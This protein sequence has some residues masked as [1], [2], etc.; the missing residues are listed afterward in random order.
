MC[1]ICGVTYFDRE[2][3]VT[4]REVKRMCD[5]IYHRGP[6]DSGVLIDGSTGLGMRRLSIIDL[7][8]GHQPISNEDGSIWIVF[9]GE[10]YNHLELRQELKK[11]GHQF[12]TQT[13]TEAIVHAYE[14]FGVDC[15]TKLN[16]MF[17][18]AIWDQKKNT[19]FLARDR[20]GIK[21]L[22]YYFNHQMLAFGSELKSILQLKEVPRE[23]DPQALDIYLTFEYIPSPYSIF[24]NIR[25][26]PPGHHLTL[27]NGQISIKKYWEL[28]YEER[29]FNEREFEE[30][31]VALL[32]DAVKIRLMSDV[33]LGALLSGGIDSSA[34]V[35]LMSREMDRPV[36]TFSIG[37]KEASYNEASYA[38]LVA[39]HFKTEHHEFTI[40]ANA[41]ELTEKL[42][43]HLDEPFGDFSIFPTYLVSKIAREYVTVALSGDGGDELFAGYDTYIA[44]KMAQVY[45]RLPAFLR[46]QLIEPS[47][48]KIS[49]TE[50][51]KG[52]INRAKRFVEGMRLPDDLQHTRWMIFLQQAEKSLLYSQDFQESITDFDTYEFIRKYFHRSSS[53]D[54]VNRQLYVDIHSYLVD[55]ILV[56]VDRMSMATSLEARVPLLDHRFVEFTARIAGRYKLKGFDTKHIFKNAMRDILPSQILKRGKEGFSIPIKNWLKTDLKSLM[57]EVL[58]PQKIK[59]EG[60]FDSDYVERL[61]HEHLTGKDNHSHRLWAM[62]VFGIWHDIYLRDDQ[63][64]N[65]KIIETSNEFAAV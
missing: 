47:L 4:E 28:K 33:P 64:N 25:K 62:M 30:Q 11:R 34:I 2:K 32:Q 42:I 50:K 31:L 55:D 48:S 24:Q 19:L 1:G 7:N 16:G 45:S 9:N 13:D 23:V 26:L 43:G 46:G 65:A 39:D 12:R 27:K 56:K 17:G 3:M 22:Y 57:L 40:E 44:N 20:L 52:L 14:E 35:A 59:N 58:A 54:T 37:F 63:P 38:R 18:F 36:K 60:F 61:T 15:P 49:P 8:S 10:I 5:V 51:K 29:E 6:D 41:L 53:R 21:P